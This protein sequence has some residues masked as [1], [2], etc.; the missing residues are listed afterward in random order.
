[1]CSTGRDRLGPDP[2][3]LNKEF[4]ILH[5]RLVTGAKP[6]ALGPDTGGAQL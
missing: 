3:V 2:Y 1:M 4:N 6:T 5:V